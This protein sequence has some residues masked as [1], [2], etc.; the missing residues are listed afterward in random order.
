MRSEMFP[1]PQ[2]AAEF[3]TFESL[4]YHLRTRHGGAPER[5]S[6]RCTTCDADFMAEAGWLGHLRTKHRV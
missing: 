5:D 6:Y 1:R 4:E 2:C 3:D